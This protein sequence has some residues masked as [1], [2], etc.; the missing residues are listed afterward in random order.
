MLATL[1]KFII[2][3]CKAHIQDFVL[4]SIAPKHNYPNTLV[5]TLM[6]IARYL[7]S[8]T[9]SSK[10]RGICCKIFAL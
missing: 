4:R 10:F 6:Y 3:K 9:R 7:N 1:V 8:I 5:L 2:E